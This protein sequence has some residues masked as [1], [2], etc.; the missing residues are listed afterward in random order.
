[1]DI[2][3]RT[4]PRYTPADAPRFVVRLPQKIDEG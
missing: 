4:T 2:L 1:M 3:P